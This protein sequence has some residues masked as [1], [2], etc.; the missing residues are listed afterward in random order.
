MAYQQDQQAYYQMALP[1]LPDLPDELSMDLRNVRSNG[2]PHVLPSEAEMDER[3]R[4]RQQFE[5]DLGWFA[6]L[7]VGPEDPR[8]TQALPR[9]PLQVLSGPDVFDH[10]LGEGPAFAAGA[11]A[12]AAAAFARPQPPPSLPMGSLVGTAAA[13]VDPHEDWSIRVCTF[14]ALNPGVELPDDLAF[15]PCAFE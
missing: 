12:G 5:E 4:Q 6:S 14:V 8:L 2:D 10:L 15:H 7:S 1:D 11:A 13:P 3:Q 9:G